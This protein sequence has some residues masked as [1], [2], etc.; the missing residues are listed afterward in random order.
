MF[1]EAARE[2]RPNAETDDD[3]GLVAATRAA[4][5]SEVTR[6]LKAVLH[7][8]VCQGEADSGS[9]SGRSYFS[10]D[11]GSGSASGYSYFS[12]DS[13]D[14]G[15]DRAGRG[16]DSS[17]H[18]STGAETSEAGSSG[19]YSSRRRRQKETKRN[20][21]GPRKG[22]PNGGAGKGDGMGME[23]RPSRYYPRWE[24]TNHVAVV[25]GRDRLK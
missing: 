2:R 11:S 21:S 1:R 12:G 16:P 25:G 7:D 13:G 4:E 18:G 5:S 9:G 24:T 20:Q 14:G 8:A 10:G 22:T 15:E 23:R 19:S 6:S 3:A 17:R